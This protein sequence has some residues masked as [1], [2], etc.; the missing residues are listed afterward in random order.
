MHLHWCTIVKYTVNIIMQ[1]MEVHFHPSLPPPPP[2]PVCAPLALT[3]DTSAQHITDFKTG[4]EDGSG[5]LVQDEYLNGEG[6]EGG[7]GG[8]GG[9]GCSDTSDRDRAGLFQLAPK[10]YPHFSPLELTTHFCFFVTESK[11][12]TR[13][14]TRREGGNKTQLQRQRRQLADGTLTHGGATRA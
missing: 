14:P 5:G 2:P 6:G 4:R 11:T 13:K 12:S 3:H 8:Q 7:E 1:L 10:A 9:G